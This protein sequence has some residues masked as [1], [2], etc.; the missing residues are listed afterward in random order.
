[1][2]SR[3]NILQ[4][5]RTELSKGPAV[6]PPSVPEIWPPSATTD[7]V[8]FIDRFS[9]ELKI[10][11]GEF[12]HARSMADAQTH[13]SRLMTEAG[14]RTIGAPDRPLVREA[15]GK[16]APEQIAW[17]KQ[18]WAPRD[19]AQLPVSLIEAE[20][21]LADTGTCAVAC[22]TAAERLLCYLP[23]ACIVI[24][25]TDRLFEHLPAAWP[26]I[27]PW[28]DDPQ[29]RGELVLI[30]GPSRTSD[31]EK[32]LILGVHGPKRLIVMAIDG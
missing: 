12:I 6:E 18:E 3:D 29:S 21:L 22:P 5:I 31:I 11:Q 1:M 10:L 7:P 13:L 16:L 9:A 15:V 26:K 27:K 20:C 4:R 2:T 23:P 14:W 28:C 8:A 25:R 32:V 17:A 30:T 24:A 19:I